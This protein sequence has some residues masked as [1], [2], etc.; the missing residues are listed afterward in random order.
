MEKVAAVS[1]VFNVD[2]MEAMKS[3]PDK[4]FELAVVDPPYGRNA[5]DGSKTTKKFGINRSDNWDC[6]RPLN[7]YFIELKRVSKNQIVWGGN[8]F[9]NDLHDTKCMIVMDKSNI[10]DD[11]I[12]MSPIELAWTS[13]DF[14]GK[15]FRCSTNTG[16]KIHPTQKPIALYKWLLTNYANPG[17]KILDTHMG[18]QSS[19]I[20]AY[21]MGFDYT[22]FEIDSDYFKAGC[23][24][25]ER[26]KAQ[27]KIF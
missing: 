4:Y 3:Y 10:P 11:F 17:D 23:E 16:N 5:L 6:H 1:E 14:P 26:F 18:S 27:L 20:A 2:C 21:D 9:I 24:R 12:T 8:Y 19:R 25:F 7:T 22:G 13:F 15:I